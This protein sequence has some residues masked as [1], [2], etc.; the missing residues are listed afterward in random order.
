MGRA[1]PPTVL[2]HR[3]ALTVRA[4]VEALLDILSRHILRSA[5]VYREAIRATG[6]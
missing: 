5:A 1:F 2:A 3:H 4:P 6:K